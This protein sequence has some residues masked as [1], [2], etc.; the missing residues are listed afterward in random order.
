M[1]LVA[2]C[3]A[4]VLYMEYMRID[5]CLKKGQPCYK[6]YKIILA[7]SAVVSLLLLFFFTDFFLPHQIVDYLKQ[8]SHVAEVQKKKLE[9][10]SHLPSD[11]QKQL[12][13][14]PEKEQHLLESKNQLEKAIEEIVSDLKKQGIK[15]A[16]TA[17]TPKAKLLTK[18][19]GDIGLQLKELCVQI[20][21][22]NRLLAAGDYLQ[23]RLARDKMA[24]RGKISTEDIRSQLGEIS[25]LL[26]KADEKSQGIT[27]QD[28][29]DRMVDEYL[30]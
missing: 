9:R 24:N 6:C 3:T 23:R 14:L 21:E 13:L 25:G 4:I 22:I 12:S 17:I 26:S 20:E 5:A 7:V 10:F 11:I 18:E 27:G 28:T 30:K 1:L 16:K 15:D 19:L 8:R 29:I 2:L